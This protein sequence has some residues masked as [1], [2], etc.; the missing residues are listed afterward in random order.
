[1]EMKTLEKERQKK[2]RG[3][4]HAKS[5][6]STVNLKSLYPQYTT[7]PYCEIEYLATDPLCESSASISVWVGTAYDNC[8]CSF[9]EP[10]S[11][12][13]QKQFEIPGVPFKFVLVNGTIYYRRNTE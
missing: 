8:E 9:E 7:K 3:T 12:V 2:Y 10:F 13:R 6:R 5:K 11:A 1:M 4:G